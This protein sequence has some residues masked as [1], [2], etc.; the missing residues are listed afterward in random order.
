MRT[1][2]FEILMWPHQLGYEPGKKQ[3]HVRLFLLR[4]VAKKRLKKIVDKN[5]WLLHSLGNVVKRWQ[6]TIPEGAF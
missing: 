4:F 2:R 1:L 6:Q 3:T 5:D